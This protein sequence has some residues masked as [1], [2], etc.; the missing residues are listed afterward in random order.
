[1]LTTNPDREAF[2]MQGET[3]N[4][5]VQV[6]MRPSVKAAG[7]RAAADD[8]RSLA[9]L[10]EELLVDHLRARGYLP[11]GRPEALRPDQLTSENDD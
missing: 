6:H 7:E 2:D 4:A 11:K 9:S 10:M 8:D 1:M 5:S 3:R